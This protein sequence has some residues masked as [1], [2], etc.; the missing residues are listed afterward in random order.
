MNEVC[1]D[2]CHKLFS[3]QCWLS[4]KRAIRQD[5]LFDDFKQGTHIGILGN[6][7]TCIFKCIIYVKP[8]LINLMTD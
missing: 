7:S 4:S 8:E 3:T 6:Q 2:V 1:S 5:K